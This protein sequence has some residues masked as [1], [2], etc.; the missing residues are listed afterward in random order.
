MLR[1]GGWIG[2]ALTQRSGYRNETKV[3]AGYTFG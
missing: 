2:M 1:G 3:V